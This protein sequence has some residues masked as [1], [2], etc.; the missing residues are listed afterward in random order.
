MHFV[1]E[2][3]LKQYHSHLHLEIVRPYFWIGRILKVYRSQ[4]LDLHLTDIRLLD[5]SRLLLQNLRPII[6]P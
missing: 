6:I 2:T 1:M 3:I 5:L 4:L